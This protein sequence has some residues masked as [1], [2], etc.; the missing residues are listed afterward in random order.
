MFSF[1]YFCVAA[2][3]SGHGQRALKV[4]GVSVFLRLSWFFKEQWPRYLAAISLLLMVALLTVIPPKVVG[5]VVDGI[6]KGGLDN[7]TLMRYLAG[8]FGLGVLIYLL[9]YVWRVMLFGASYRLAYVLRNRLFSH[10]TRMS[11]DFYQRHR[12]GDLMAHATNDIQAVEMTAGEGVLTLVDSIMVGVLVLSIMCSQY[13]WQLTLVSLLP[14]PVMAY[15]MNRFGTQ[16]YTQFQG[17]A[18]GLLQ[19][20]Q[21]DPGGPFRRA[22]VEI[23]CG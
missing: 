16:I 22:G 2:L 23:L 12:T 15:F 9:R 5:W 8:L 18:R 1:F 21:Q 10:F 17:G 14:L 3:W 20:Q 11:P 6:T 7:G 13:S 4:G 19:A